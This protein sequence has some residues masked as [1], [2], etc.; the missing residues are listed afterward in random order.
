MK[1]KLKCPVC[2]HV[3]SFYNKLSEVTLYYCANCKN[4]FGKNICRQL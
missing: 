1:N 4:F 3:A 2:D